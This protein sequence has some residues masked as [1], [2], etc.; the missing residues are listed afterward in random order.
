MNARLPRGV[1][2][3][4]TATP[5]RTAFT[6]VELLVVVAI[7]GVLMG[8]LLPAVQA[9]REAAR[10]SS[11]T[12]NLR[13]V[14]IALHTYAH[15]RKEQFPEGWL[16]NADHA[17][18][19]V[20][21]GWA[22]RIL[23][24]M[25]EAEVANSVDG[26]VRVGTPI[27]SA[28]DAVRQKIIRPFLCP[29]DSAAALFFPGTGTSLDQPDADAGS[30][31]F[32]RTN[33]VGMF[34]SSEVEGEAHTGDHAGETDADHAFHGNGI[35]FAN[36]RM[37]FSH[38]Q[39]GLS[40]TIMVGERDSR[41]GG[42][43]W[44]G[45]VEGL[46]GPMTRVVGAGE[47]MFNNESPHFGDFTSRHPNGINVVFADGHVAFL[48]TSLSPEIFQAMSTRRSGEVVGNY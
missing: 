8:L 23:P 48:Q 10:R 44:I 17:N 33:Y 18:E 24:Q 2:G 39:D 5:T 12:N 26:F 25:E 36:S 35:F 6:L 3:T 28:S 40:K 14:G 20:G 32:A 7:I 11:C 9:A 47:H 42:S 1:S 29:S 27:G 43:L 21:W 16:C 34:G 30:Q 46:C 22:S 38:I 41:I 15:A 45:M 37:P 19:G 13:Q 31:Q 4:A